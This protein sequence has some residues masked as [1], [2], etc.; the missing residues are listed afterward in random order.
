MWKLR[1]S[2]GSILGA[3]EYVDLAKRT[4]NCGEVGRDRDEGGKA[5]E[6]RKTNFLVMIRR[7]T[8]FQRSGRKVQMWRWQTEGCGDSQG[9]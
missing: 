2:D 1:V 7:K 4:A 3:F 8:P 9:E 6:P 5:G